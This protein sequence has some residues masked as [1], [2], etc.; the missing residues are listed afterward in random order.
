M[1]PREIRKFTRLAIEDLGA[2]MNFDLQYKNY[3]PYLFFKEVQVNI[4][5]GVAFLGATFDPLYIGRPQIWK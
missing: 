3:G 1:D 5:T 4:G 2:H